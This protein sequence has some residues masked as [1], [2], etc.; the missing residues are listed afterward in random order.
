MK[1]TQPK[2][3]FTA[4]VR[5]DLTKFIQRYGSTYSF[6]GEQVLLSGSSIGKFVNGNVNLSYP[7]LL[8]LEQFMKENYKQESNQTGG[9]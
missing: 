7:A 1:P 9:K 3:E 6:I 8:R 4:Q 5:N 2:E